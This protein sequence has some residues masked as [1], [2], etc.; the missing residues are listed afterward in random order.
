MMMGLGLLK[1]E[2]VYVESNERRP[3]TLPVCLCLL[4]FRVLRSKLVFRVG[5]EVKDVW[6]LV[7]Q[8][9]NGSAAQYQH[10]D[11]YSIE[12]IEQSTADSRNKTERG[13]IG[14]W[15][16]AWLVRLF[17]AAVWGPTQGFCLLGSYFLPPF[18]LL[19][20]FLP[21]STFTPCLLS[22]LIV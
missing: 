11:T 1:A 8:K 13:G 22:V 2:A 20:N 5:V 9:R 19:H 17:A 18:K 16:C 15:G 3:T 10:D 12:Q 7:L 21:T 14:G 4:S 6:E